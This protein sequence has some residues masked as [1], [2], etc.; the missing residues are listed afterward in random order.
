MKKLSLLLF[1]T[2]S[3]LIFAGSLADLIIPVNDATIP[4]APSSAWATNRHNS[5]VAEAATKTNSQIIFVGASVIDHWDGKFINGC[6][7]GYNVWTNYYSLQPRNAFNLG[8][9][10]NRTA[11]CLWRM[12]NGEIDGLNPKIAIVC[13][14]YNNTTT[15][16]ETSAGQLA[17]MKEIRIRCPQAKIIFMPYLPS[18]STTWYNR[19]S[20]KA[21]KIACE[22]TKIDNMVYNFEVTDF[23][24]NGTGALKDQNLVPDNVHPSE[25]GYAL[26]ATNMEHIIVSMLSD[27]PPTND[28][29]NPPPVLMQ[30]SESNDFAGEKIKNGAK[31]IFPK[32]TLEKAEKK[33]VLDIPIHSNE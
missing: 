8:Q 10:G 16:L 17:I 4:K 31:H 25:S 15:P 11:D 14:G 6:Q 13:I 2:F 7:R 27:V 19:N 30:I 1:L 21:Y 28:A 29:D 23:F 20:Y 26:W 33:S 12:Q 5:F 3:N 9:S 18:S 24:T 22:T 32:K